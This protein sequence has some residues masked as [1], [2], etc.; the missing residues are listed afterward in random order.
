MKRSLF[1]NAAF[2]WILW[3]RLFLFGRWLIYRG[4]QLARQDIGLVTHH[5]QRRHIR[6]IND[7]EFRSDRQRPHKSRRAFGPRHSALGCGAIGKEDKF[8]CSQISREQVYG[9]EFYWK[10]GAPAPERLRKVDAVVERANL[11]LW[12]T[13]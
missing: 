5:R 3:G 2:A 4:G 8:A 1:F 7:S 11:V 9:Q 13:P 10:P 6:S 12:A